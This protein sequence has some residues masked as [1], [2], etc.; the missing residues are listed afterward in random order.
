TNILRE[1][2]AGSR[3][4]ELVPGWM[5]GESDAGWLEGFTITMTTTT[6]KLWERLAGLAVWAGLAGQTDDHDHHHQHHD[7]TDDHDH[8]H[9]HHDHHH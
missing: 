4:W 8:Q 2:F 5:G 9:Q 6:I 1:R 3:A 7:H